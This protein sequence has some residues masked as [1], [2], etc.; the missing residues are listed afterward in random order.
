MEG[1]MMD[2]LMKDGWRDGCMDDRWMED[3]WMDRRMMERRVDGRDGLVG[4][5]WAAGRVE[6]DHAPPNS[7]RSS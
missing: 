3:G 6:D 2:G 4:R 7:F 5:R 1:W